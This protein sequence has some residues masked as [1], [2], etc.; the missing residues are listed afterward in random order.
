MVPYGGELNNIKLI[1]HITKKAPVNTHAVPQMEM[2]KMA[3]IIGICNINWDQVRVTIKL[4]D[5]MKLAQ[6]VVTMNWKN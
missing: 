3:S 2:E 5:V 1:V 4:A 6:E